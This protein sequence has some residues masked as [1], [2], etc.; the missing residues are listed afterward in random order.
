MKNLANLVKSVLK[1][2]EPGDNY[3]IRVHVFGRLSGILDPRG[4]RTVEV[5][6]MCDLIGSLFNSIDVIDENMNRDDP[7]YD[8]ERGTEVV[9][10]QLETFNIAMA[11]STGSRLSA[12]DPGNTGLLDLDVLL[13]V[14]WVFS[15][16]A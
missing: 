2:S 1:Y 16:D 7:N 10:K 4:Y 9:S 14:R 8:A 3:D 15:H 5:N 6:F 11:P 12:A 13:Q